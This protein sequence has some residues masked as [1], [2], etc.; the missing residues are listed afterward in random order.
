MNVS[1]TVGALVVLLLAAGACRRGQPSAAVGKDAPAGG[2]PA[3]AEATGSALGSEAAREAGSA[4]VATGGT[5]GDAGVGEAATVATPSEDAN[6]GAGAPEGPGAAE[7]SADAA[8]AGDAPDE[9][10]L[11]AHAAPDSPFC[12]RPL[13][14]N[15]ELWDALWP[16]LSAKLRTHFGIDTNEPLG[17]ETWIEIAAA[18][19]AEGEAVVAA[20]FGVD[21]FSLWRATLDDA[22]WDAIEARVDAARRRL[23]AACLEDPGS[24]TE[25][26]E[27][28]CDHWLDETPFDPWTIEQVWK[29]ISPVAPISDCV[30]DGLDVALFTGRLDAAGGVDPASLGL[31]KVVEATTGSR[32]NP[33]AQH[34]RFV[35]LDRDGALELVFTTGVDEHDT[36]IWEREPVDLNVFR[37]DLSLQH[38]QLFPGLFGNH[39]DRHESGGPQLWFWFEDRTGDGHPDLVIESFE[40]AGDCYRDP[41][42]RR[43]LTGCEEV[44]SPDEYAPTLEDSPECVRRDDKVELRRA[45]DPARDGWRAPAG[46]GAGGEG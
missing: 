3:R 43:G 11:P 41:V 33:E 1:R 24:S 45:Y 37:L 16:A 30:A 21:R 8:H 40:Y 6:D 34:A 15:R 12:P 25:P 36:D 35:D 46:G 19:S 7:A 38:H 14:E 32:C 9:S 17:W 42:P 26:P 18:A 22:E 13:G 20:A 2:S 28:M 5:S 29:G 23:Y 4:V 39:Q 31:V 44:E 10:T 27:E